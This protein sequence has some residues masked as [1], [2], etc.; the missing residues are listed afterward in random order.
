MDIKRTMIQ[1]LTPP[2]FTPGVY[3]H[4]KGWEYQAVGLACHEADL[5]WHVVYKP[6][7]PHEGMPDVWIRPFDEFM[8]EVEVDGQMVPRF[9]KVK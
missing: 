4:Y 1:Q 6:L 8:G 5:V 2:A 7:Y 9:S 3:K